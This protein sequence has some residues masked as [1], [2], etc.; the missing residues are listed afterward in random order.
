[1]ARFQLTKPWDKTPTRMGFLPPDSGGCFAPRVYFFFLNIYT[2]SNT[3][4]LNE[5]DMK[6][7]K[8]ILSN[9]K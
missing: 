4:Q 6:W 7:R 9:M 1:M 8:A 2:N 5:I 3:Y